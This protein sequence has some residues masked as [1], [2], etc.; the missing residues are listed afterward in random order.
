[1]SRFARTHYELLGV[2]RTATR[3][4]LHAAWR[5]QVAQYHPDRHGDH[6]LAQLAQ[7][8]VAELNAAWEE[9][10]DP[11]RRA[12]YDA[13]LDGRPPARPAPAWAGR[14]VRFALGMVVVLVLLRVG[15]ILLRGIARLFAGGTPLAGVVF[16]A[17]VI[18]AVVL[19][20]RRRR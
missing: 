1:M 15:P 18:G 12:R 20:R 14:L 16:L 4:E 6:P 19:W 2:A 9:L 7:E 5:R 3:D 17:V 8:R 11:A 10:S 13:A